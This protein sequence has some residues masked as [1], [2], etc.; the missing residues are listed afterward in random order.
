MQIKKN[1]EM[2]KR[3]L[4]TAMMLM[5][6]CLSAS[7]QKE[8]LFE[9]TVEGMNFGG[10]NWID[11]SAKMFY[12]DSD[13]EDD[14]TMLIKNYKKNGNKEMFDIYMKIDPSTKFQSITIITDPNLKVSKDMNLKTQTITR[15][16]DDYSM[17]MGFLTEAQQK[18]YDKLSG[19][20]TTSSGNAV[21]KAKEKGKALLNKG[22]NLFKKKK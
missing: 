21:D 6:L 19:K 16:G 18:E 17:T 1:K 14:A 22:K 2:M 5:G 11:R 20:Q 12:F 7:A 15:K 13:S 10:R 9:Y 3:V 4:F 8:A